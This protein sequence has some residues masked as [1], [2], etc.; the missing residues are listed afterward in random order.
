M[1]K[2]EHTESGVSEFGLYLPFHKKY[3]IRTFVLYFLFVLCYDKGVH[4][5]MKMRFFGDTKP[6]QIMLC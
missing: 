4:E 6:V 1:K 2:T 3:K 5:L